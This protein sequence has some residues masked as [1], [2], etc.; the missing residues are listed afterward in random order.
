MNGFTADHLRINTPVP[1]TQTAEQRNSPTSRY[2]TARVRNTVLPILKSLASTNTKVNILDIGGAAPYW[3]PVLQDLHTLNCSLTLVN[4]DE[5]HG[6][7]DV[8][9]EFGG[10]LTFARGDG[11]NLQYADNSFAFVH[12]SS[13][14]EHVGRWLDMRAFAGEVRRLA[15]YY[16]VQAPYFWFPYEPHYRKPFFHWLPENVRAYWMTKQRLKPWPK[17]PSLLEACE[18]V[19]RT[20]LLDARQMKTLFPD[21]KIARER[22]FGMTKSLMAVKAP[23]HG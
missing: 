10:R 6:V 14:I 7:T 16:Y 8:L 1:E 22:L 23:P 4:L 21:A 2:R 11:R 17:A 13:V 9:D 19:E 15:P 18:W 5:D 3:R 20:K 12:S